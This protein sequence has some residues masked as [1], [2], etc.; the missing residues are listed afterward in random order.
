MDQGK[1]PFDLLIGPVLVL[2]GSKES[3]I[4]DLVAANLQVR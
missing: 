4:Q 2:I 1:T 3:K